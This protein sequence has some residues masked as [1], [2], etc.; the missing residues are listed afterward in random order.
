M[1]VPLH[2]RFPAGKPV[3][4]AAV[5]YVDALFEHDAVEVSA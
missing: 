5:L 3:Q 4:Y 1:A 2:A